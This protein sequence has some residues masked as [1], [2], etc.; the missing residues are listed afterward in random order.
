M[1]IAVRMLYCHFPVMD[2]VAVLIVAFCDELRH[3]HAPV[4]TWWRPAYRRYLLLHKDV[5]QIR[6]LPTRCGYDSTLD[7]FS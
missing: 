5:W 3:V 2:P 7:S 6:M 1:C 4:R